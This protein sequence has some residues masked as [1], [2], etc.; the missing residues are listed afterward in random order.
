MES[1]LSPLKRH[2]GGGLPV[3]D[4]RKRA[5]ATIAIVVVLSLVSCYTGKHRMCGAFGAIRSRR[6]V[7]T[8]IGKRGIEASKRVGDLVSGR[9]SGDT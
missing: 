6:S 9:R 7:G 2:R 4:Y 1:E 3:P 5:S 8:R